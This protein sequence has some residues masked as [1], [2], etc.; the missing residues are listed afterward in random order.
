[1]KRILALATA[2]CLALTAC[3]KA[4]SGGDQSAGAR[5]DRPRRHRHHDQARQP[6]RPDRRVRAV[7]QERGA[8]HPTV[9]ETAERRRRRVR[10]HRRGGRQGPRVRPAEGR[11]GLP[12]DGRR[13]ARHADGPRLAR[14]Q[15]AAAHH[16]PGQH[17]RRRGR[18]A[19]IRARRRAPATARHD[20]R[21]RG[22]HRAGLPHAYQG[23]QV[24]G[25]GRTRL[26]RGRLRRE[27]PQGQ[28]VPG[29]TDGA[30]DRR[31]E[32][33]AA[34]H[35]PVGPGGRAPHRR[36]EGHPGLGRPDP[37]RVGGRRGQGRRP[38]GPDRGQRSRVH[39][40]AARTARPDRR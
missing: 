32:D 21:H 10:P 34:G 7:E 27:R 22:H 13:R 9:L 30:D 18:M 25:Q 38:R 6:G 26:L 24:R 2:L 1:M 31:A 39:P 11:L 12:R 35:R 8:G 23:H 28:P 3:S 14:G 15:R 37:D 40:A 20:V 19:G 16:R 5:Q 33:P 36:R 4:T 17:V 29:R